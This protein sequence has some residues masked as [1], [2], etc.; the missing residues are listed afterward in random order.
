M[1]TAGHTTV[2]RSRVLLIS[3]LH[4]EED[5]PHLTQAFHAFLARE[6]PSA[7][8]LY[9]LGDFFNVWLGD[10][11]DRPLNADITSAL[12][13]CSDAGLEIY[14][15]HG[16]RDFLLGE[17]FALAAGATLLQ[18]PTVIEEAGQRYLL[19]HGDELCTLDTDYQKFRH[20]VRN[21]AWQ[22][23]FLTQPLAARRAFADQARA[24]SKTMNSNKAA[25]IMDVTPAEVERLLKE[26]QQN[27]TLPVMIHG[28]THR[29][30]VHEFAIE[31]HNARRI[32]LGDWGDSLWYA[33]L[34]HGSALLLEVGLTPSAASPA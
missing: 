12:R 16:N 18:G 9:I 17:A 21:P 10:D 4:L 27:G 13:R 30:A 34:H 25:D 29:P 5:R 22:Q 14:L 11:D 3:D 33:A 7:A 26:Q 8:A 15:L 2:P 32:V 6:T 19:L 24:T 20:M 23:Q 1:T 28:H 31:G